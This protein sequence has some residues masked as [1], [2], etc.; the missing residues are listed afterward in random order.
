M[1]YLALEL[2]DMQLANQGLNR[3]PSR[4]AP[5]NVFRDAVRNEGLLDFFGLEKTVFDWQVQRAMA[6]PL[7]GNGSGSDGS[8]S[9]VE[10]FETLR[11]LA[12]KYGYSLVD[13]GFSVENPVLV[14]FTE[15]GILVPRW[16][17]T[18]LEFATELSRH[19]TLVWISERYETLSLKAK[20]EYNAVLWTH[21]DR[22]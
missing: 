21:A 15:C 1:A 20:L 3:L 5:R 9:L 10:I 18:R 8:V 7:L 11:N 12:E 19:F 13:A 4:R 17:P 14:A 6:S 2:S 22:F 16:E